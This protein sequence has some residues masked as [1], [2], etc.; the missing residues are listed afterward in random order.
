MGEIERAAICDEGYD[1]DDP[2]VVAALD[3]VRAELAG[4]SRNGAAT[5]STEADVEAVA[6]YSKKVTTTGK[7]IGVSSRSLSL[8]PCKAGIEVRT[9]GWNPSVTVRVADQPCCGKGM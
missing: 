6:I 1:P 4:D 9:V 2:K 3:R 8:P 7:A 5:E